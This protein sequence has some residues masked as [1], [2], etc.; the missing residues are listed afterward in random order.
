[1]RFFSNDSNEPSDQSNVD[2]QTRAEQVN[3]DQSHD[4]AE[5]PDHVRSDPVAVPQQRS[6][7][8]WS[9]APSA[10]DTSDAGLSEQERADSGATADSSARD[11]DS[12]QRDDDQPVDQPVDLPLDDD[13]SDDTEPV[14][15]DAASDTVTADA[16]ARDTDVNTD[17]ASGTTT[18]YGPDGTV[19]THDADDDVESAG[20]DAEHVDSAADDADERVDSATAA[21]D[22]DIEADVDRLDGDDVDGDGVDEDRVDGDPALK[23]EGDFDDPTAVEPATDKPLDTPDAVETLPVA[24]ATDMSDSADT[25]TEPGTDDL[26]AGEAVPVPV[27]VGAADA[28][29]PAA[30]PG[31][32]SQPELGS[33]F[34]DGDAQSFQERWRE[35]QLRF[36]DSP[37]EAT[38]DAAALIDEAVDKLTASLKAQKETVSGESDDT[39]QLRVALRG[40][41]D[42]L[43]R[44]L[45]L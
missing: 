28:S 41:R 45:G 43:N 34:A 33:V 15:H 17:T 12:A 20:D 42:I 26:A 5:H 18:T 31:S 4:D 39:E 14:S 44:I 37:K 38:T 11:G 23:D 2:V 10:D 36:V 21:S 6:G 8:P 35:V 32:V 27:P 19:V 1:M 16:E 22:A 13:R 40:Y 3:A 7:S 24:G 9:D 29:G 25:T 30:K